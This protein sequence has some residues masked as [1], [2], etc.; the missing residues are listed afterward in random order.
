VGLL[1]GDVL[2]VWRE[3]ASTVTGG[4]VESGHYPA[5]EAPQAVLEAFERFFV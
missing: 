2:A 4:A 5:E 3:A 1:Y